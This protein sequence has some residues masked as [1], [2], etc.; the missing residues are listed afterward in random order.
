MNT[1]KERNREMNRWPVLQS[2]MESYFLK[3]WLTAP[4]KC[5]DG[6]GA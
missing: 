3:R 6:D 1:E 4:A 2:S 5:R